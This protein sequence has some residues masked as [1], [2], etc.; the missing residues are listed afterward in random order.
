MLLTA[1][2]LGIRY[3]FDKYVITSWIIQ[4][5]RDINT[6]LSGVIFT[7]IVVTSFFQS[8]ETSFCV[9]VLDAEQYFVSFKFGTFDIIITSENMYWQLFGSRVSH[10]GV[11]W[12][13]EL[14]HTE[15]SAFYLTN[16]IKVGLAHWLVAHLKYIYTVHPSP[17]SEKIST[18]HTSCMLIILCNK[19]SCW[20]L[21]LFYYLFFNVFWS[22]VVK[23]C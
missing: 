16:G 12:L 17:S 10:L 7:N 18:S 4:Y 9:M 5:E 6:K 8:C 20:S 23:N 21:N 2:Y 3:L 11:S 19:T 22:K 1:F 15:K 13:Y 14:K